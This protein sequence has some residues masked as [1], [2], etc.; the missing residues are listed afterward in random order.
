M[1]TTRQFEDTQAVRG[2]VPLMIGLIGAS[3]SGKTYSALRMAT[4]IQSVVGGEI[5]GLDSE[6]RRMLHYADRFTFRHVPFDPPFS[7]DDYT[8]GIEH[9]VS[10]GAS[11][12]IIDSMSHEHE[13]PGGVL[14]MHANELERLSK[15]DSK[16]AERVKMLAWS[17]PKQARRR[18]INT[19][20]QKQVHIIFCFRAK[21]KLKVIPGKQPEPMGWCAIGGEELIYEMT[22]SFLLYPGC[23]GRPTW[24]P[25]HEGEKAGI[26]LPEQFAPLVAARNGQP[27]D[28]DLGA[29][30]AKWAA[31]DSAPTFRFTTGEYAGKAMNEVPDDYLSKLIGHEKTSARARKLAEEEM[32]RRVKAQTEA[33]DAPAESDQ[34]GLGV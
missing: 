13:G 9:C 4:G 29:A 2:Q 25:N 8:D 11:V 22:S 15:G 14:E 5:H 28:E 6:A 30:M 33:A 27:L 34:Q 10:R 12:V 17:K 1:R 21:E 16:K 24:T 23:N 32:G 18:M 31:G 3:G 26:K 7:P 19:I 20:L